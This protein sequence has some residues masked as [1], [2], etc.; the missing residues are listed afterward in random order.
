MK[1]ICPFMSLAV[2][3]LVIVVLSPARLVAESRL[4][5]QSGLSGGIVVAL[6]FSD[7]KSIAALA[8]KGN[9]VVQGLLASEADVEKA[10]G[11]IKSA[12]LYGKVSCNRYN[13]RE[14]PYVC[15]LYTSPSPR[16]RG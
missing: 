9:F 12:G 14:L 11:E 6:N 2:I 3:A 13:G 7:G 1:K 8:V 15:L 16:D 10:R 4:V 5:E